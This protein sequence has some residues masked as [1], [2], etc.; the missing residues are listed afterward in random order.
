MSC[1]FSLFLAG[2]SSRDISG[3]RSYLPSGQE[4]GEWKADGPPQEFK[5]EDLYLY[6][7]GGAEIYR[8]Y[9]FEEVL[10]Q[11]YRDREGKGLSLEIFRMTSPESAYGMYTFKRSSRGTPIR[12]GRKASSRTIT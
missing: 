3:L 5:G 6:I 7:D 12:S 1:P 11:E 2:Q 9:G 8:E 4:A 10:V